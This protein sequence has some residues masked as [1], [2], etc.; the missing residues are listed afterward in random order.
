MPFH[1]KARFLSVFLL[2]IIAITSPTANPADA[3]S[4]APSVA[5]NTPN[6][7]NVEGTFSISANATAV[8]TDTSTIKKWCLT[9]DSAIVTTNIAYNNYSSSRVGYYGTFDNTTGCWS[10]SNYNLANAIFTFDSTTWTSGTHTFVIT[11]TDTTNRTATS[12][13]LTLSKLATPAA[14]VGTSITPGIAW[15]TLNNITV[16]GVF[17]ISAN[18]AQ[19]TSSPS[20]VT[21][22]C[23]TKDGSA[24]TT[25][26][27]Y[28]SFG[29][30]NPDTGCWTYSY[31]ITSGSLRFDST[32]WADGSHTF[33]LTV[34]DSSARTATS[35]TLTVNNINTG[36]TIT[37]ATTNNTTTSG[38]FTISA[39]SSAAP[40]GTAVVSKWCLTKDGSAVTT[41]VSYGSFGTFNPDTGCWTYSSGITSG[42]FIFNSAAWTNVLR[43]Y[44]LTVTDSS[45]RTAS[46]ESLNITT[47]NPQPTVQLT[48]GAATT[49]NVS[50]ALISMYHPGASGI[51]SVCFQLNASQC[52]TGEEVSSKDSTTKYG[53]ALDTRMLPNGNYTVSASITD[54]ENRTMDGGSSVLA[55]SNPAASATAAVAKAVAPSW[56]QKTVSVNF[57]AQFD[58][59]TNAT[60]SWGTNPKKLQSKKFPIDNWNQSTINIGALKPKTTY[61][62]KTNVLGPNGIGESKLVKLKT[63]SIPPKPKPVLQTRGV[64]NVLGYRL[65][66]AVATLNARGL[67]ANYKAI[68][69]CAWFGIWDL[70]H[71]WVLAQIG[72]TLYACK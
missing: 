16:A 64:P 13:T 69:G 47:S 57:S 30:F 31:G 61:Y 20:A 67:Y 38:V 49:P 41:D 3:A 8:A 23:L 56:N 52:S 27:S 2:I 28:G 55:V 24:V 54:T 17:I 53:A 58:Y 72:T 29:T 35:S 44:V 22:W 62:F 60:V 40:S 42:S 4:A 39:V 10:S 18:S 70:S 14:A 25:D 9:R 37:W 71:W 12:T 6:N 68:S 65:D 26:V 43:T 7:G 19:A 5:W 15:N 45:G 51:K 63:P 33:V 21:K 34:T 32:T 1:R 11:V 59:A 66:A 48:V 50:V 36:P 46:T